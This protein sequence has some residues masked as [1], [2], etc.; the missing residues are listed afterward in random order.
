MRLRWPSQPTMRLMI[1]GVL[2]L[3]LLNCDLPQPSERESG[4]GRGASLREGWDAANDPGLMLGGTLNFGEIRR[5]ESLSGSVTKPWSDSYWP[6]I[7]GGIARRWISPASAPDFEIAGDPRIESNEA[8]E[9]EANRSIESAI[10]NATNLRNEGLART[11]AVSPA[12]KYDIAAGNRDFDLTRSEL[13]SYAANRRTYEKHDIPWGWMGHCHGWTEVSLSLAAPRRAVLAHNRQTGERV[14]FSPGDIRAL[15][16]KLASDNESMAETR[17]AGTR[18]EDKDND[19]PRDRNQRI[20][21]AA[22]GIWDSENESLTRDTRVSFRAI[23]HSKFDQAQAF[24]YPYAILARLPKSQQGEPVPPDAAELIW[25]QGSAWLD[26]QRETASPQVFSVRRLPDGQLGPD[27]ILWA[28]NQAWIGRRITGD[29]NWVT[30]ANGA[31]VADVAGARA[32]LHSALGDELASA[33]NANPDKFAFK[34]FKECRDLNPATFH[35]TL[36]RWLGG[37]ANSLKHGFTLDKTRTE[38]VW[39]QGVWRFRS[40][41]GDLTPLEVNDAGSRVSD[42]YRVWRDPSAVAI[43]D[44]ETTVDYGLENG[45]MV[46]YSP[47]DELSGSMTVRYTLEFDSSQRLV[48]AEWHAVRSDGPLSGAALLRDLQAGID[49]RAE[50]WQEAPDFVWGNTAAPLKFKDSPVLR[51]RVVEAIH[52]CSTSTAANTGTN[53]WFPDTNH[54]V[55]IPYISCEID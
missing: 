14:L 25:V 8:Y 39:N 20:V 2:P 45:P 33:A 55:D 17:F 15:L 37:G 23:F 22:L 31:I 28:K 10:A 24:A 38:Q 5:P 3:L 50:G 16:T 54:E 43:A 52:A 18:C 11:W 19:I 21:D 35:T 26:Q 41:V 40:R 44:V 27:M 51:A 42:P 53:R 13:K 34:S 48:G 49:E 47:D 7:Q 29:G 9:S 32:K 6:L 1:P 46:A 30:D 12:E 36:V 4:S